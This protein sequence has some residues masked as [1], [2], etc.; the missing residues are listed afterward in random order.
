LRDLGPVTGGGAGLVLLESSAAGE[1]FR[2]YELARGVFADLK[3]QAT[4]FR[5][6]QADMLGQG[7]ANSRPPIRGAG[8]GPGQA[9]LTGFN[10]SHSIVPGGFEVMS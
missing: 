3:G 8:H 5:A 7:G 6:S 2:N 4:G 1:N 10:H 9:N